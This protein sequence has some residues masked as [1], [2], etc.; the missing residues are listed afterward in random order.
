MLHLLQTGSAELSNVLVV[1]DI[2]HKIPLNCLGLQSH[3]TQYLAH[4][5]FFIATLAYVQV[6]KTR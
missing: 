6:V 1:E 5:R 3:L 2:C 4:I